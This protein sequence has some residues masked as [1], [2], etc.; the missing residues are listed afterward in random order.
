MKF[1]FLFILISFG[2]HL[3][4]KIVHTSEIRTIKDNI[5]NYIDRM[6]NHFE[7]CS[8]FLGYS[9]N[10][11]SNNEQNK[12]FVSIIKEKDSKKL[13]VFLDFLQMYT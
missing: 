1:L 12:C 6:G 10:P 2:F 3:K 5:F 7:H 13:Q 8:E 4:R 11:N 9:F